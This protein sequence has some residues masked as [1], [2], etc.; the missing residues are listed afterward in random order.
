M[1]EM[2]TSYNRTT[3]CASVSSSRYNLSIQILTKGENQCFPQFSS[4]GLPRSVFQGNRA[5]GRLEFLGRLIS[6]AESLPGVLL[7]FS[8]SIDSYLMN[9]LKCF[10]RV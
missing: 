10:L 8:V 7:F 5:L 9:F 3:F 1:K 6:C 4:V 2:E